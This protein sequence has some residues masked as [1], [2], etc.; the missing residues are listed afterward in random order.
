MLQYTSDMT[1][2]YT[3]YAYVFNGFLHEIL[4]IWYI[5]GQCSVYDET[6]RK[7]RQGYPFIGNRNATLCRFRYCCCYGDQL[8]HSL[9]FE[10]TQ[11]LCT[12][13]HI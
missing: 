13:V 3:L 8:K 9:R 7:S 1:T 12:Y 6:H 5:V 4:A 10:L 11:N 2:I